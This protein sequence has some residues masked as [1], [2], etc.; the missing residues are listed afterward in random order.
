MYRDRHQLLWILFPQYL[1]N[2]IKFPQMFIISIIW[3]F[4]CWN[5]K[6]FYF[7]SGN[8]FQNNRVERNHRKYIPFSH[9][10]S[11][12]DSITPQL[13]TQ[14]VQ[15]HWGMNIKLLKID[16]CMNAK[17]KFQPYKVQFK[18]TNQ[19]TTFW[20]KSNCMSIAYIITFGCKE[21]VILLMS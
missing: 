4:G 10:H 3:S 19:P 2:Y 5:L 6:T 8:D 7:N 21:D 20:K 13:L 9:L 11:I 1:Q 12:R 14:F 17:W 15:I 18:R 16:R